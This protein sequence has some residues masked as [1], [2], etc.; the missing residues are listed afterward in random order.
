MKE[1]QKNFLI[2]AILAAFILFAWQPIVDWI[3]PPSQRPQ[4][5]APV[6][7]PTKAGEPRVAPNPA[8]DPAADGPVAT[9]DRNLVIRETPRILIDTPTVR[10]SINLKGA[11]I[12][13]LV[14]KQHKETIARDSAPIRLLSPSGAERAYFAGF[15]W[16][17]QNIQAPDA[18]TVWRASGDRLTPTTPV[19]LTANVGAMR[20]AIRIAI[21]QGYL[22]TVTQQVMN[23]SGR[24]VSVAPYGYLSRAGMPADVDTWTLHVGPIA[25]HNGTVPYDAVNYD[26]I[27]D[28]GP[29]S[30][31]TRGGWIGFTDIY[32]LAALVPDQGTQ[33]ELKFRATGRERWQADMRPTEV[34]ILEPG[35]VLTT[36]SKLFAGAKV[37]DMLDRYEDDGIMLFGKAIDWGWFEI[38][39]KPIFDYLSFLFH[40]VG[41]FGVAIILLTFSVRL[42]VFP[43]AQRGF[44]SMAQ[45]RVIQPKMKALQERYKDDKPRLQQEMMK[46]Y[47]DEKV[48]PL[49]G[50]LPMLLQIPIFYALYK[51]L[52]L[53]I[54]MRHQPFILW[55]KDLAAPDPLTP[56]NLFG[57]LPY[58]PPAFIAVGV[59]P[60]LLGIS[61]YFQFKLNP[62]P[63]DETQKQVFAIMPWMMMFLMAPF[64]VGLQI[65]WITSNVLTIAQQWW[66]YR[67]HPVL[68]EKPAT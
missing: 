49:A 25:A 51:V 48:N 17:G 54:E 4:T 60:I 27:T 57:L 28:D 12:D 29:Q 55:I 37:V 23:A 67:Q 58:T 26:T 33:S 41:N 63:M 5:Q 30:Y 31:T 46:L 15:G 19:T 2:F 61:M 35:Q 65:Y 66:L 44:A 32:W 38:I 3:I 8:A 10:G 50:C 22:F 6:P 13:D 39:E 16:S 11:R 7:A 21:D 20:Y 40:L 59:I 56:L 34:R 62:A 53:T 68:T 14:L 52:M 18:N 45:M 42:L 36:R 43:I 9:R 24:P 47:K 1:E 64:A